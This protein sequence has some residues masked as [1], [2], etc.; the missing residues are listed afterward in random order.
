M[1]CAICGQ[2]FVVDDDPLPIERAKLLAGS[3]GRVVQRL[4]LVNP[5]RV[6]H[7]A[8]ARRRLN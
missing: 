8:I 3:P 2:L 1:L 7:C 6:H 4:M 5:T